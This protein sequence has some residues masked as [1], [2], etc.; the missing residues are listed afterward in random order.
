MR[1]FLVDLVPRA[2]LS[3]ALVVLTV[4]TPARRHVVNDDA[5]SWSPLRYGLWALGLL[6]LGWTAWRA[7]RRLDVP[8]TAT[9]AEQL[10]GRAAWGEV[11]A[12]V[13][14]GAVGV[15]A[16]LA[17]LEVANPGGHLLGYDYNTY[18]RNAIALERGDW[19]MFN[20][21]KHAFHARVVA[22]F[23]GGHGSP[24]PA[25]AG[26]GAVCNGLL[27]ALAWLLA[28][29][30]AGPFAGAMAA[31]L[32]LSYPLVW[33]FTGQTT[34]YP[35]YYL[36]VALSLL[37]TLVAVQRPAFWSAVLAGGVTAIAA[38]TS[39]KTVIAVAPV[40]GIGVGI[41][42]VDWL[43]RGAAG[44]LRAA[45]RAGAYVALGLATFGGV[46]HLVA[47]PRGY[48]PLV[49]LVS[50]QRLD[51]HVELPYDWPTV[52][53]PDLADPAGIRSWLPPSLHDGVIESWVAAMRTPADSNSLRLARDQQGG[54]KT[55]S[56]APDTT[57]PPLEVRL[58][59]NAQTLPL[60]WGP[61]PEASAWILGLAAASLALVAPRQRRAT[62]ALVG[63]VG[64]A[65]A[66]LT[67]RFGQ[68]YYPHL[69][70]VLAAVMAAG[71]DGLVAWLLPGWARWA[72]RAV[73][74]AM[75]G[76]C[77]L[78]F[79]AND[80]AAWR[81]P[82][83]TFPPPGAEGKADPAGYATS[84]DRMSAWL[85]TQP[86]DTPLV[87]CLP[88]GLLMVR[89]DDPRLPTSESGHEC[90]EGLAKATPGTILLASGHREY[91]S[92]NHPDPRTLVA[93]GN[94]VVRAAFQGPH[95]EETSFAEASP[96]AVCALERL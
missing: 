1:R 81:N 39:E 73:L 22:W 19:E 43:L 36:L 78:S 74:V 38:A 46:L 44:R 21:D 45:A 56:V 89:A 77:V 18:A 4:W 71:L 85:D 20:P 8:A 76:A 40:L 87:D 48:T 55:W 80:P 52:K 14:V 15:G 84:L 28:R 86:A 72:G 42:A 32:C 34:A 10:T 60:V 57:L 94:W 95:A 13:L 61:I 6:G 35:L 31:A 9:V 96:S 68:H 23:W 88:G 92:P 90:A 17:W 25:M 54:E 29:R 11:L 30:A 53:Q 83:W 2:C 12:L 24:G 51:V 65:L 93:S 62:V 37:T 70:P 59:R 66:P 79:W 69:V 7:W 3:A 41:V 27:P 82:R 16:H 63:V 47:P 58:A 5:F 50:N 49:S 75:L 26:L 64:S 91:R 33:H 67:L